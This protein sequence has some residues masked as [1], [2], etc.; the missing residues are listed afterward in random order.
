LEVVKE[1]IEMKEVKIRLSALW[2][3][4]MFSYQLADVLRLYSGDYIAGGEIFGAQA[5]QIMW[6]AASIYMVIPVAMVILSQ[7]LPYKANRWAN[8]ILATFFFG[9]NL[10]VLFG[11]ASAYDRFLNVVGLVFNVLTVWYAWKWSKTESD[12][13]QHSL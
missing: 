11:H 5:T 2:V 1:S 4:L 10:I 3:A 13:L 8:I 9:V 12:K 6:L 7:M